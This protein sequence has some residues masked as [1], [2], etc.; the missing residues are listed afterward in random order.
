AK[1]RAG[2]E[3]VIGGWSDTAGRFRSLL[4]GV[5]RGNHLVYTG[6]VGTGYSQ[7]KVGPLTKRLEALASNKNPFGGLN[8]PRGA[9]NVHWVKPELVAEIEF[10]GW[11][12]DGM[13]RQAAFKGLRGDKPAKD[14]EA[15]KPASPKKTPLVKPAETRGAVS[16]SNNVVMGVPISHADKAM[17]PDDGAGEPITKLDLAQYFEKVGPWMIDHIK[18]RPCSIVR[19]PDG[20]HGEHF[21]QRHAM[22]GTSNLI[23][24]VKVSGDRQPYLQID[25]VE[26]LIAAEQI[27]GLELHPWNCEPDQPDVPGRL[28]F[29]F[30]PAPDVPF[31]HVVEGAKEI[32]GRLEA[33]GLIAFCKTTG[34]KGLHVVTPLTVAK[35]DRL[36]W[37]DAKNFAREIC[38][39]MEAD[40]PD[41]YVL[42]MAKKK[43][44]GRI[45]LDYL[46]NDRMA[47]AVAPLSPRARD[48]APVSMPLLWSQVKTG[49]DPKRFTIRTAQQLLAKSKAWKDY[50]GAARPLRDAIAKLLKKRR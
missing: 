40:N 39:R 21:F 10:A 36:G 7:A 27:A 22:Q 17:W 14:V 47:T 42:N 46:R 2:Q 1:C 4:V 43:R 33:L 13:V 37:A 20:I 5:H 50:D 31:A 23:E 8:A 11:T 41:L 28:V 35:K 32:R 34:G 6:R 9:G 25:R 12:E 48:G 15:E 29:D 3:V 44:G 18:G 26:G 45:F 38:T 49:L 24:L 19:A 30:D 16:K